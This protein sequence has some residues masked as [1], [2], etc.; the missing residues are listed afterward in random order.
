[1]SQL[2]NCS[3]HVSITVQFHKFYR[4]VCKL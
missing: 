3:I 2:V 1:M 4:S